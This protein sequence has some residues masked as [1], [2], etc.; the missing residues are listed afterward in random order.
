DAGNT[1]TASGSLSLTIDAT[2]PVI[3]AVSATPAAISPNGDLVQDHTTVAYTLSED[4]TVTVEIRDSGN[5]LVAT[6]VAGVSQTAGSQTV[7]WDGQN[8]GGSV[9]GDGVYTFT[10]D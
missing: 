10:I 8:S 5:A 6:L 3:S 9:V 4:A 7:P 2:A 1:S